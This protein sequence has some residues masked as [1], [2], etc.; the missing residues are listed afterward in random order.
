M[1]KIITMIASV[2]VVMAMTS[3]IDTVPEVAREGYQAPNITIH[4]GNQ[5]VELQQLRGSAV[6]LSL[7]SSAN[8]ESRLANIAAKHEAARRG[9]KH[10]S[11][12]LDRSAELAHAIAA[13]DG[14]DAIYCPQSQR[15][16]LAERWGVDLNTGEGLGN[17][18]IGA[19]GVIL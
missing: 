10:V 8:P 18:H 2:L 4:S 12:N 14:V 7:W 1:R 3:A 19:D 17:W 11:V 5:S 15:Q 6:I 9:M 16:Q 13:I